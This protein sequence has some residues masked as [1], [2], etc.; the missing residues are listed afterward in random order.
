MHKDQVRCIFVKAKIARSWNRI[1]FYDG[2][3]LWGLRV[4]MRELSFKGS[5]AQ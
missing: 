2:G 3:H 4:I 5:G 1:Q